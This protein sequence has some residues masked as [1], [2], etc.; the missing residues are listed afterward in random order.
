MK[1]P[2]IRS[3]QEKPLKSKLLQGIWTMNDIQQPIEF[4]EYG[5]RHFRN[6]GELVDTLADRADNIFF[7]EPH[8][9]QMSVQTYD[10]FAQN[11]EIFTA[12]KNSGINHLI[13]EF[14]AILQNELD[15]Y[16]SGR[17]PESNKSR[18][19]DFYR[20]RRNFRT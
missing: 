17:I 11:P 9:N 19:K 4:P 7:G 10:F 13:L 20:Q 6:A 5:D 8:V 2:G 16:A 18:R 12:A 15:Q 14:P 1:A 3:K